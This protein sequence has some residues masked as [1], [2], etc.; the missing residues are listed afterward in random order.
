MWDITWRAFL[1]GN[2]KGQGAASY[3]RCYKYRGFKWK[4]KQRISD[5]HTNKIKINL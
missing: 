4:S 5:G 3:V 2:C 1:K